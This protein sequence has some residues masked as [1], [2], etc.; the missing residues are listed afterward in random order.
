MKEKTPNKNDD[1]V[2]CHRETEY[3][4]TDHIDIRDFYIEGAGQLCHSCFK[5]IYQNP[6]C[7]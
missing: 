5:D 3:A 4:T 7:E 1:C 6:K 2:V